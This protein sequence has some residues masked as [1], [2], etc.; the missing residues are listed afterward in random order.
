MPDLI[1]IS[2]LVAS[3][4]FIFGM[5][6]LSSVKTARLGNLLAAL[7]MLMAVVVTLLDQG[8]VNYKLIAAGIVIGGLIG[9]ITARLVQMTAM[10]QMVAVFNGFGGL[11]SA[12]VAFSEYHRLGSGIGNF[13]LI[14]I[15]LGTFVGWLTFT[16][17]MIAYGKLQGIVTQQ[18]VVYPFQNALNLVITLAIVG[19]GVWVVIDPAAQ[20]FFWAIMAAASLLGIL[21]VLPIG[22]ADMPVVISLLNSYSGIAAAMTGFVLMNK[23][24]I[25]AGAL[26]GATGIILT[27]IMCKAMNRSLTN[28]VFGAFGQVEASSSGAKDSGYTGVKSCSAEEA[29]MV[30]ESAQSVLIV[31]GY[32]LAVARAQHAIKELADVLEKRGV[33]VKYAIHPVAGRMPG[34]MNVLLAEAEVPYEQLFEMDEINSEFERTDVALVVGANDV[35]NPVARNEV[36]S[37]IYGMPILNVDKARTVIVV[38]RSLSPG[39]A[40]IK[41][42]L[43][44]SEKT[45][46]FFADAKKAIEGLTKEMNSL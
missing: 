11:A 22:G 42:P 41:N 35:T 9:T 16:G 43:F 14:T 19:M 26:V 31:P 28:V 29:A 40:G 2:Y 27:A 1:D 23:V 39:F 20:P 5:K 32:G 7:A 25:V 10:P 8:I 34:H 21:L 18:P 3:V 13:V 12:L 36:G 45:L 17:S 37:P 44:E 33:T 4:L 46:M 30:M 15:L 24:L 38:K 6:C